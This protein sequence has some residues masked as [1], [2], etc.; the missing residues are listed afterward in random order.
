APFLTLDDMIWFRSQY[1]RDDK[2]IT[3]PLASPLLAA[4]LRDLPP[5]MIVTAEYDPL[6]D[7]GERYGAL[8]QAAGGKAIVR[9]QYGLP[10][11]FLSL[12]RISDRARQAKEDTIIALRH[13]LHD[14]MNTSAL[15]T[16][17]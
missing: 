7:E 13:A 2:D 8:L 5:A 12:D 14:K 9:R 3:D 17:Q 1:L 4:N 16:P 11:G 15:A 10:H 6:R